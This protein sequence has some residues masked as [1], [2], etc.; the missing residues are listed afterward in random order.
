M[1]Y[2]TLLFGKSDG[3]VT[4]TLNR[5]DKSNAFDDAQISEMLD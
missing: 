4:I 3:I 2:S 1:S 5:P